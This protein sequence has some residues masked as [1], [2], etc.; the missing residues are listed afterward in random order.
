MALPQKKPALTGLFFFIFAL[1]R[2]GQMKCFQLADGTSPNFFVCTKKRLFTINV[3]HIFVSLNISV[4]IP[5]EFHLHNE[6]ISF[7]L[8]P[9]ANAIQCFH[10]GS[11]N[12]PLSFER[13]TGPGKSGLPKIVNSKN[14][15]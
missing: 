11:T 9:S 10:S 7:N 4:E 5:K 1:V 3:L 8:H 2:M 12:D 15:G 6:N 13:S 14:Q